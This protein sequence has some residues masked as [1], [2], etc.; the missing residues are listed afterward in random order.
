MIWYKPGSIKDRSK[1]FRLDPLDTNY[2][3]GF[4]RPPHFYS[5][6]HCREG[7]HRKKEENFTID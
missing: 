7:D 3:L 5:L 1:D 2:V 4:C 6:S